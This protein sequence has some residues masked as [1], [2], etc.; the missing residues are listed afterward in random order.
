M[1]PLPQER[2]AG[3]RGQ[4]TLLQVRGV[5]KAFEGLQALDGVGFEVQSGTIKSIIGPNGAGKTTLLNIINGL[6][7]PDSGLVLFREHNLTRLRTDRIAVLG[8]SRTFQLIRL[9]TVNK[10]TVLDNVL[11]GAH[12]HLQPSITGALFLRA[13]TARRERDA[14]ARALELLRFVGLEEAASGLPGALSFGKQR[15]L[16]LAR[17]LMSDPDLLLLDEPASGLNDAEVE[18]FMELLTTLRTQGKTILLVE[19]NMK[20]VMNISDDVL[21]LNFGRRLAEGPPALI[22]ADPEVIRAYLGSEDRDGWPVT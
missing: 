6:L 12:R 22:S 7:T 20:L 8:I 9:F 16:E 4:R 21:V 14:R 1:K 15:L 13:R 3:E 10:A 18:R 17:C 11:L 5:S 19:H 2:A